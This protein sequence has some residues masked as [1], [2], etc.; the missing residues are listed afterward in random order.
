[1]KISRTIKDIEDENEELYKKID[2]CRD[3][4]MNWQADLYE[5]LYQHTRRII[6]KLKSEL[7]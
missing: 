7:T 3:H 6:T 4:N 2:W 1:M 5:Q